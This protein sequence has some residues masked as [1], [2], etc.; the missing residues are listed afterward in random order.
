MLLENFVPFVPEELI[1][2]LAG[3]TVQQGN[4]SF[5]LTVLAGTCGTILGTLLWYGLGRWVGEKRMSRWVDKHGKW[6]SLTGEDIDRSKRW[7]DRHGSLVVF[8]GR[9]V[10]GIRTYISIP[11]GFEEMGMLPFLVFSFAGTLLWVTFLTYAGYVLGEN[12]Q[13]VEQFFGP[14]STIVLIAFA[15]GV[16]IWLLQR[17]RQKKRARTR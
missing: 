9:F 4:L 1:M 17:K 12:Y 3:F 13:L 16:S 15:I 14:V 11:A 5:P 6:L 7:F 2:P 8:F 10:P